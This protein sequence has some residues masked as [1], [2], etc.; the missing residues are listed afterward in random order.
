MADV[1]LIPTDPGEDL[2]LPPVPC[3]RCSLMAAAS[4]E[5][6]P[7]CGAG[8]VRTSAKAG[9][10][11]KYDESRPLK[12]ALW[13]YAALLTTGII[14]G[15]VLSARFGDEEV[16][17]PAIAR[18]AL[19]QIAVVDVIDTIIVAAAF[20]A[21]AAG[22]PMAPL[23]ETKRISAWFA[24]I[25]LLAGMLAINFFYHEFLRQVLHLPLIQD[26]VVAQ[27]GWLTFVTICIQP[28]IVEE[29]YCRGL[30]MGLLRRVTTGHAA[31]WI[32]AAMFAMM[33]V[34]VLLSIPYL[35]LV[36]LL[37]GYLRLASGTI[38]LPIVVH[39]LHNLAVLLKEWNS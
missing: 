3:W 25:P 32:A 2:P 12:V 9:R 34:A 36:G 19:N 28:A 39:F 6:C 18:E 30:A 31:V 35:F 26:E 5:Y 21:L 14:H 13:S 7:H 33:H 29:A 10:R 22:E 37:L 15:G 11:A 23:T 27:R 1:D 17:T 8:L 16:I 38:W 4:D 24:A 20:L